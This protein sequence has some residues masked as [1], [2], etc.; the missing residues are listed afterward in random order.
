MLH[1]QRLFPADPATRAIA[2]WLYSSVKDL[3]ILSPHGHTEAKW[4]ADNE[5]FPDPSTLLIQPDH[6]IFRMLYSQGIPLEHLGIGEHP[7]ANP[8]GVWHLFAKHYYLFRGTPTRLWLD[9][10]FRELFG[11]TVPLSQETADEY[12]DAMQEKL[13]QPEFRP[14]ALFEQFH[15]EVLA[16]TNSPLDP[17]TY[18]QALRDSGLVGQSDSYLSPRSSRRSRLRRFSG[19][20]SSIRRNDRRKYLL[21]GSAIFPPFAP[22]ASV[23]A[24]L[25]ALPPIT[26]TPRPRPPTSMKPAPPASSIASFP[27][28]LDRCRSR[29]LPR[30]DA[31]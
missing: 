30:A 3:P 27:V 29:T 8:R 6:Y 4:F 25:A 18:H 2:G 22:R 15:I 16:T 1:P 5:P 13:A 11:L 7:I 31:D 28:R 20:R 12:Y 26:A 17:L 24:R 9:Y 14:R 19:K 10:C 23:F 21:I